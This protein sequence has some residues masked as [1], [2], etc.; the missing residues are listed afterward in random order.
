MIDLLT[1]FDERPFTQ[2]QAG[3]L[4]G[5][6]PE[7]LQELVEDSLL[8]FNEGEYRIPSPFGDGNSND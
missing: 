4:C 1:E 2:E 5:V 8:V 6:S 7:V 3:I